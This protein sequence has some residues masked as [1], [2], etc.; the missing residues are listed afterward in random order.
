M[1]KIDKLNRENNVD[2]NKAVKD[3]I[4]Q[5]EDRLIKDQAIVMEKI[6]KDYKDEISRLIANFKKDKE[7]AVALAI[8]QTEK[9]FLKKEQHEGVGGWFS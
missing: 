6:D 7:E 4:S 2:K 1:N 5:T 9:R 3:A 8:E